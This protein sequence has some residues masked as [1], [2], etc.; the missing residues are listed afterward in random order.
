MR[1]RAKRRGSDSIG[2]HGHGAGRRFKTETG[3]SPQREDDTR[4]GWESFDRGHGRRSH[5]AGR[6]RR[7]K[8]GEARYVLLDAL[9]D[10]PKHG[11]EIIKSL[12]ERSAGQYVSSPGTVYPTMQYLEELGLVRADQE[13]ERRVYSLTEAGREELNA[14]AEHVDA[15]WGRFAA[16]SITRTSRHE[17]GFLQ[18]ELDDLIRTAWS[19]LGE[20]IERDDQQTIRQVR[21]AVE[22][23]QNEIREIIS[24]HG[25]GKARKVPGEKK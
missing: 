22:L 15:F 11:Y 18:D 3:S 21:E 13:G 10:G 23:C 17:V 9:R 14:H 1:Q 12:E 25:S 19:G 24:A 5:R 20:A 4:D 7:A 8:R 2:R 16:K 6:H